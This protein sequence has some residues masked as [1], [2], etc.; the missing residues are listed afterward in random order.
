MHNI[1]IAEIY[2]DNANKN[3][4]ASNGSEAGYRTNYDSDWKMSP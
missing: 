3:V 4:E 2:V 1:G